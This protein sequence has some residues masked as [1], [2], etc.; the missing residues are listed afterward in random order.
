MASGKVGNIEFHLQKSLDVEFFVN[1]IDAVPSGI[2]SSGQTGP[3][4]YIRPPI[5]LSYPTM[6]KLGFDFLVHSSRDAPQLFSQYS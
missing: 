6:I 1:D 4:R 5:R 3:S 2:P